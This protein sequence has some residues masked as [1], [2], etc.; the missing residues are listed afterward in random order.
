MGSRLEMV[1]QMWVTQPGPSCSIK[2]AVSPGAMWR[3]SSLPPLRSQLEARRDSAAVI[4]ARSRRD[5]LPSFMRPFRMCR[6]AAPRM[7][8]VRSITA[9]VNSVVLAWPLRSAVRMPSATAPRAASRTAAPARP[10]WAS[11]DVLQEGRG[12]ED[13]GQGVGH[14]LPLQ[15]RRRAV[16]GLGHGHLHAPVLAEGEDHRLRAGDGAEHLHHQVGE[17]VAVAVEGRD[18]HG[19]PRLVE[20]QGVEGVDQHRLVAH[21]R[22]RRGGAIE[23]LLEHPLVGGADGVLGA[24]EDAGVG[25]L[26]V[27]EG[28]LGHG[29]ADAAGDAVGAVGCFF[30]A[31]RRLLPAT[32][33]P[34]TRRRRPS[35]PPRP[36]RTPR[37]PR[38]RRGGA[39]QRA[40]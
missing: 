23:L 6:Q 15:A 1:V 40:G 10:A 37:P 35:V 18:D 39:G 19:V 27:A 33:W 30:Q 31:F 38:A 5:E 34:G 7:A 20:Q 25:A 11:R 12:G 14:V 36:A 26:G 21:V 17:A 3:R 22:V 13:H 8:R 28:E 24:P 4:R 29:A 2:V 9:S 32:P 16:R